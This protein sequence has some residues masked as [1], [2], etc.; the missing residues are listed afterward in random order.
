MLERTRAFVLA[1][2]A[3]MAVAS[4][5]AAAPPTPPRD[6]PAAADS[7]WIAIAPVDTAVTPGGTFELHLRV[8]QAGKNFNAYDA[9]IAYDPAVLTFVQMTALEQQGSL[10]RNACGNTFHRF[11]AA[12]DSLTIN[13]SLLCSGITLY[14]PGI[15]YNLRF[16]ASATPQ[17]THVTVRHVQFYDAGLYTGPV[18]I[19]N[20]RT[21]VGPPVDVTAPPGPTHDLRLHVA[22]N[23]FNP[24][25]TIQVESAVDWRD[26][27]VLD[28]RGRVV[29]VLAQG[30]FA[31]GNARWV[32]D[33]RDDQGL[34]VASGV[35]VVT[36]CGQRTRATER[37]V[38]VE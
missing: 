6:A 3:S 32:W 24:R 2:W 29:R 34:H 31:A 1:G 33:G 19:R 37:V 25:T 13:H 12:G 17:L 23:P 7:I 35:Y 38:L 27:R 5:A 10:M 20:S 36:V 26:L 4:A 18:S 14:G 15:L 28:V 8:T 11:T 9:I 30:P 16:Q 21:Q 22:P